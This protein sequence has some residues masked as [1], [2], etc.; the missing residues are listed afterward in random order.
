MVKSVGKSAFDVGQILTAEDYFS[1]KSRQ[2]DKYFVAET[3]ARAI[4]EMLKQ[5]DINRLISTLRR[6]PSSRRVDARIETAVAFQQSLIKPHWM[7]LWYLPV[8]PAALRTD[9]VLDD[10]GIASVDINDLYA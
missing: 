5:L 8:L 3:G 6:L 7:V 9:L 1:Y 2:P 10:G 4:F